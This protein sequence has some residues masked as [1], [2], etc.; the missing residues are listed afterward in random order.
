MDCRIA[1]YVVNLGT[2]L[3][4]TTCRNGPNVDSDKGQALHKK[5]IEGLFKKLESVEPGI[6]GVLNLYV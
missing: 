3:L 1:E 5:F 4:L 6:T 2:I